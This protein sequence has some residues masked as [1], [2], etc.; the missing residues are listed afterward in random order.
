[1]RCTSDARPN[2]V[3][4]AKPSFAS[5]RKILPVWTRRAASTTPAGV[6]KFRQPIPSSSPKTPQLDSGG[7]PSFT[8]RSS[9]LGICFIELLKHVCTDGPHRGT[10]DRVLSSVFVWTLV[11]R[12]ERKGHQSV[13]SA[14]ARCDDD[15]LAAGARAVRHGDRGIVVGNFSTPQFLT[16]LGVERVEIAVASADEDQ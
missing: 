15:E 1:M 2:N 11:L 7:A 14:A 3:G 5:R 12:R 6:R 13:I 4:F 9:N 16:G 8:G 10:D